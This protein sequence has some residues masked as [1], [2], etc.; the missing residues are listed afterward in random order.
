MGSYKKPGSTAG[1][2]SIQNASPHP[3]LVCR[4]RGRLTYG[5]PAAKDLVTELALD[6]A[7]DLLPAD[8]LQIK[9][10]CLESGQSASAEISVGGRVINWFYRPIEGESAVYLFG[11][12]ITVHQRTRGS[13]YAD[14]LRAAVLDQIVMG[15]VAVDQ[16]LKVLFTNQ[17]AHVFLS[18]GGLSLQGV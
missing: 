1:S 10:A 4:G 11:V 18:S 13:R 15:V 3:V 14:M 2:D 5:N 12:D 9:K 16:N 17:A 7:L 8:H 6:S